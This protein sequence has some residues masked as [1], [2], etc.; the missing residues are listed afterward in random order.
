MTRNVVTAVDVGE[1]NFA[2]ASWS[3]EKGYHDMQ[4]VDLRLVKGDAATKVR[5]LHERGLFDN[6]T[7]L[8][9]ER[10]M[11]SK[12]KEMAASIRA[13]HWD[14]CKLVA[15]LSVKRVFST[16]TKKHSSNK[17]AHVALAR[18]LLVTPAETHQFESFRKKDDVADC[19]TM[20]A[21]YRI[22]HQNETVDNVLHNKH[23]RHT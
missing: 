17:K 22:K 10:Q 1:R 23:N 13:W 8:L 15:P 11:R 18:R 5:Q 20:I 19:I 9:V 21:W 2:V 4:V 7:A 12:F 16:S 14:K 6:C 3:P